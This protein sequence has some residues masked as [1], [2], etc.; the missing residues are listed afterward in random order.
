MSNPIK[1][2]KVTFQAIQDVRMELAQ[3]A[4]DGDTLKAND[5]L[6]RLSNLY[7]SI[8]ATEFI[9]CMHIL[10]S[11]NNVLKVDFQAKNKAKEVVTDKPDVKP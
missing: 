11:G 7:A 10:E 1:C 8:D 4:K 2:Y 6:S 5:C 9:E 3:H